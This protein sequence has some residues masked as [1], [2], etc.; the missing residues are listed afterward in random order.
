MLQIYGM[1]NNRNRVL[2]QLMVDG[3]YRVTD[4]LYVT[5]TTALHPH[6]ARC[7]LVVL[8]ATNA[9][10]VLTLDPIAG[11]LVDSV[12]YSSAKLVHSSLLPYHTDDGV[13]AVLLVDDKLHAYVHPA[14]QRLTLMT[15]AGIGALPVYITLVDQNTATFTGYR[16]HVDDSAPASSLK[17]V[18]RTQLSTTSSSV[19]INSVVPKSPYGGCHVCVSMPTMYAER[20][21]SQG[22]V[23]GDRSVLYKYVNPNLVVVVCTEGGSDAQQ[24]DVVTIHLLDVVSGAV[25]HTARHVHYTLPPAGAPLVV[26]CENWV[27][28]SSA[29]IDGH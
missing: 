23:L 25:L 21:H 19:R 16:L 27:V 5:R 28:V 7:S 22:R 29:S 9:A 14:K 11:S 24:S 6:P 13:Q 8:D 2:W 18:W 17:Q 1:D 10:T 12:S 26:H 3:A 4:R 15:T 20:V